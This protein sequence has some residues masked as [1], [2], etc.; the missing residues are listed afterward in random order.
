MS[1]SYAYRALLTNKLSD[2]RRRGL[3]P[4][5]FFLGTDNSHRY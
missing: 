3:R 2:R 1:A 5:F 4:R